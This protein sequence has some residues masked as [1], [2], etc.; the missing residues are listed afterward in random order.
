MRPLL[1]D[2]GRC[3]ALQM[4]LSSLVDPGK[5]PLRGDSRNLCVLIIQV[6]VK[7]GG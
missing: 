3:A 5:S 1:L 6:G 2:T 4:G 7:A